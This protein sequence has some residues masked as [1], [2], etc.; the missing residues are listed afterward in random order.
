MAKGKYA[1]NQKGQGSGIS[2]L[3]ILAVL[4]LFLASLMV[5]QACNGDE[6]PTGTGTH[7]DSMQN[8][9]TKNPDDQSDTNDSGTT[10]TTGPTQPY[11][12]STASVGVTGDV[13]MHGPVINAAATNNTY[14]FAENYEY[15]SEYYRQYDFMV[16]NLEVTLGGPEAGAYK[17]YPTFNCPDTVIDALKNAGV[18][19]ILTAN[20]H[21][22][23]TGYKGFMR[24]QQVIRE[25]GLPHLGTIESTDDKFYTVQDI[26]GIK[27]GMVCYTYETGKTSDG[28][29]S[30]NGI[31]LSAEASK[32]VSS[33]DYKNLNLFYDDVQRT[34]DNMANDGAEVNMVYIH[35]GDEYQLKPNATQKAIAQQLCE[36][37]VDVIVGGHPH[38]IQPFET[39]T[40]TTGEKT[41]CI[42]SLGNAISNQT[43]DTLK[44]TTANAKYTEDGMIFGVE[45]QKWNDGTV[46]ISEISILP[47]WV[48]KEW[49][50]KQVYNIIPL[51]TAI[52]VWDCY[53]VGL[54]SRTYESYDRT[55]SI[56]AEGLNACREELG[57]TTVPLTYQ[58]QTESEE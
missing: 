41:Y 55:M 51:D 54:E 31:A 30:L 26:N 45:F 4:L 32:L 33:F 53:D 34:L 52:A 2:I 35:W 3:I 58:P 16:A 27:V 57:L 42:Y 39:L 38:V 48:N 46:E 24:T 15:I 37:G 19:M 22:Y 23:D 36:L 5:F 12:V 47:T 43:R 50:D 44:D 25:K 20:N 14:D 8:S 9:E 17:G 56:V 21:S 11:V 13:L 7:N 1:S 40:S 18:D 29:K 49:K 6:D 10:G 28:R